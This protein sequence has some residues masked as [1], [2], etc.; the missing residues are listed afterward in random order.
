M[1]FLARNATF[2]DSWYG[3]VKSFTVVYGYG[4]DPAVYTVVAKENENISIPCPI[5]I[6]IDGIVEA[7]RQVGDKRRRVALNA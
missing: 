3:T 7:E 4:W 1:Q 2:G 6:A 5:A